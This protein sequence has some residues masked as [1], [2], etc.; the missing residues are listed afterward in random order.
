MI[1]LQI[2]AFCHEHG[3][4]RGLVLVAVQL[5]IFRMLSYISWLLIDMP[6]PFGRVHR[7]QMSIFCTFL[8]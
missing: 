1:L 8:S 2:L 5:P 6:V 3:L 7:K 4:V